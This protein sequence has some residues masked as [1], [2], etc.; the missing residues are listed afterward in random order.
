MD[1]SFQV[2][3]LMICLGIPV[4]LAFWSI[5]IDGLCRIGRLAAAASILHKMITL[6]CSPNVV[7]YT[8][9]VKAFMEYEMVDDAL[10]ILAM[11]ENN[12]CKGD[13]VL[14]NML[15]HRLSKIG[16]HDEALY[17]FCDL[18]KC[19]VEPDSYTFCS[20]LSALKGQEDFISC[21]KS[22]KEVHFQLTL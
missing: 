7:T 2:L 14:Y 11:M 18:R 12:G 16:R 19:S 1:E 13:V 3:G 10:R 21:Q 20:L 8:S 6:G 15:I 9:L 22:L 17:I 5:L 4:S